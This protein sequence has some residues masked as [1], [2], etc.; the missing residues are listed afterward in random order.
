MEI[1]KRKIYGGH[2]LG[3]Q[4]SMLFAVADIEFA[5]L[6][7]ACSVCIVGGS[8]IGPGPTAADILSRRACARASMSATCPSRFTI[9]S[10]WLGSGSPFGS[11]GANT[12]GVIPTTVKLRTSAITKYSMVLFID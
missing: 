3:P 1:K 8:L 4:F 2:P 5:L 7:I 11:V 9:L 10:S 6:I 12:S